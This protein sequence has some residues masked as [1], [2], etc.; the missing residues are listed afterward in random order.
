[1]L[2]VIC[3]VPQFAN[4]LDWYIIVSTTPVF[5][6]AMVWT[7]KIFNQNVFMLYRCESGTDRWHEMKLLILRNTL[8]RRRWITHLRLHLTPCHLKDVKGEWHIQHWS[9]LTDSKTSLCT[10]WQKNSKHEINIK[11]LHT[12]IISLIVFLSHKLFYKSIRRD[13]KGE[14]S[15]FYNIEAYLLNSCDLCLAN[16]WGVTDHT[17]K[18]ERYASLV[19][20]AKETIPLNNEVNLHLAF[21]KHKHI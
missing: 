18:R 17:H 20:M 12:Q 8:I 11:P 15:Y 21:K 19:M 14:R 2:S 10:L 5:S 3:H 9:I 7:D 1:M 16:C 13:E 6:T 4:S